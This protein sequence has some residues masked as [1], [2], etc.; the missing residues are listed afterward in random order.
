[1][2]E[3]QDLVTQYGADAVIDAARKLLA[4]HIPKTATPLVDEDKLQ[5][6]VY[7]LDTGVSEILA[8]GT[9]VEAAYQN[10]A[11]LL[12]QSRQLDTEIQLE[13]AH[14]IMSITGTGKDAYAILD[15]G[16]RVAITNDTARDAFRRMASKDYRTHQS[17]IDAD[18][19]KIDIDLAKAKDAYA[20][21]LEALA[22]IRAKAN[23]QA[24][25]LANLV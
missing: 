2:K 20:T 4:T 6:T 1:M 24:N 11:E 18:V 23:L 14:A 3:L 10:K 13:E 5:A 9:A 19:A 12:K 21:K 17:T 8:A 15:N 7:Q 25:I 22:C 16:T